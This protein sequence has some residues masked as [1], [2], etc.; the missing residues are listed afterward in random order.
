MEPTGDFCLNKLNKRT[1]SHG[2]GVICAVN[3]SEILVCVN[4]KRA[5]PPAISMEQRTW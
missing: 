1:V 4:V 2:K 3:P 5:D